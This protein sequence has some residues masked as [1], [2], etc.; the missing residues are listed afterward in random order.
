MAVLPTMQKQGIGS[1][2]VW[3]GLEQCRGMGYEY[4]VVLGHPQYY[5]RFGFVPAKRFGI[6]CSWPVPESVFMAWS[7]GQMPSPRPADW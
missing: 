5:P 3:G 6:R 2:L 1:A 4:A 7:F